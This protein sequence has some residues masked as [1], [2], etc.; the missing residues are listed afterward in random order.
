MAMARHRQKLN[1]FKISNGKR[2]LS[3]SPR[4]EAIAVDVTENVATESWISSD[5]KKLRWLSLPIVLLEAEISPEI[6]RNT[7]SFKKKKIY[8]SRNVYIFSQN[9]SNNLL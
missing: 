2:K 8:I 9:A 1:F 5:T 6:H 3:P 7:G 4:G